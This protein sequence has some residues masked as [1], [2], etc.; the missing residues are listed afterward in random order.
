LI[1]KIFKKQKKPGEYIHK[2][3]LRSQTLLDELQSQDQPIFKLDV[4]EDAQFVE[5]MLKSDQEFATTR[6]SLDYIV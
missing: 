2:P 6:E 5:S 4:D 1:L 3:L